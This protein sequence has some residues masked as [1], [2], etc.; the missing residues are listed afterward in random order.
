M[1]ENDAVTLG[2]P[3]PVAVTDFVCEGVEEV[4]AVGD[5][6]AVTDFVPVGDTVPEAVTL[7]VRDA[8]AVTDEVDV[9]VANCVC[10]V[11]SE[12]DALGLPDMLAVLDA[13]GLGVRLWDGI[14][15]SA[16]RAAQNARYRT[17][18]ARARGIVNAYVVD[19][20]FISAARSAG[21][22]PAASKERVMRTRSRVNVAN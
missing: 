18:N 1:R 9:G 11:D 13:D 6:V 8:E 16:A 12:R 4:D 14:G 20:G 3:E 2:V 21:G 19:T 7:G 5:P 17:I 22:V 10:D 15:D